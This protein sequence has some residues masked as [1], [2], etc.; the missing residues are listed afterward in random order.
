MRWSRGAAVV[1]LALS[2]AACGMIRDRLGRREPAQQAPPT[3]AAP[4]VTAFSFAPL[5]PP[6]LIAHVARLASDEF[7]GRAPGT[8]GETLTVDY[9]VRSFQTAGLEP[10]PEGWVQQ[11]P[12]VTATVT[13]TPALTIGPTNNARTFAYGDEVVVWTKRA[14]PRVALT[15]APLVFVGYGVV[16]PELGWNDYAGV[17]MRGKIAVILIN[18][19]DFET[20]DDRGFR[21]RTMT[22]YGRWTYKIDE[23]ARHG[24]AGVLLVHEDAA[25]A[26]PWAVVR[27][28]WMSAQHDLQRTDASTRPSIEGWI[29]LQAAQDLFARANLDFAQ[30]KT[31]AQRPSFTPVPMGLNASI[32]IESQIVTTASHNVIGVLPGRER[33]TE[34]VLYSAH[35]DH[36]GHCQPVDGDDICNGA[37]DNA[38]GVAGLIEL[39]RRFTEGGRQQRSVA[40]IAFTAE[41]SGLLGSAYYAAHPLFAPERTAAIINMDGLSIA[42][43]ASDITVI[44]AGQN[45]LEQMLAEAARAQNRRVTLEA[46]PERGGFF[47]S[48]HFN[49]AKLG[50]PVLYTAPGIDLYTGGV[51]RGRELAEAYVAQRYHKPDDEL[52]SDWD[53]TGAMRDLL[54]LFEVGRTVAESESWPEWRAGNEFRPIRDASRAERAR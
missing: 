1:A 9:I 44:G 28:S 10:G 27:S 6:A 32:V 46:F 13:N 16:N 36:L 18:D 48:D 8:H 22:Y 7:E 14:E 40:F 17:D 2:L 49:L 3:I 30:Q 50:V 12:I 45:N 38:S 37:R 25:A 26:Y 5:T 21:G 34:A 29:T 41:E 24:A 42:G 51:R 54:L 33:P 31:R 20:G 52:T 35:W 19:P 47:R 15:N 53:M 11:V 43:P 39:A 23:A 4:E